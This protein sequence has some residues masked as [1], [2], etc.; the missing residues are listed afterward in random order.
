MKNIVCFIGLLLLIVSCNDDD[1]SSVGGNQSPMGEVGSKVSSSS[2]PIMGV[3]NFSAKVIS[4]SD[5]IS[6]F[7]ATATVTNEAV[8]NVLSNIPEVTING[9]NVT[10]E[11]FKFKITTEGI[12]SVEGTGDGV[13]VKYD[14]KVGDSYPIQSMGHSR[15]VVYRS[16]DDDYDY[17]FFYIKVVKVEVDSKMPGVDKITY[18]ANHKFGI[19]AI[20]FQF[21]DG[22]S[23]KFPVYF[24]TE[25][26]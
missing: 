1:L 9:D 25:N 15:K 12:E 17:G 6:T 26:P 20:D 2:Q 3:S 22:T 5:G 13:I 24:N 23:A 14:A 8:K 19:V 16:T 10:A 21:D 4:L 18:W 11:G 7:S